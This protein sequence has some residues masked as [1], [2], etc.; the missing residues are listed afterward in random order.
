M[1]GQ[2]VDGG[3]VAGNDGLDGVADG[4]GDLLKNG[5]AV[6]L[7][8]DMAALGNCGLVKNNWAIDAV[9]CGHLLAGL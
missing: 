5:N 4:L 1:V 3:E 7:G 2:G 6:D 8:D 9:L